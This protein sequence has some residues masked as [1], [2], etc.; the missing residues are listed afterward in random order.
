MNTIDKVD[1]ELLTVIYKDSRLSNKD[2]AESIGIAP[3]TSL[4]RVRR[5][6]NAGIIK[7]Y[8]ADVDYKALGIN[9]QVMAAIRLEKHSQEMVNNFRDSILNTREVI[10]V[11]HMG[12]ENDFIVHLA[13][14]DAE[15]LRDFVFEA[16]TSRPEVNHV[17]TAVIYEYRRSEILPYH[18]DRC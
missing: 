6:N 9:M 3:S 7:G 16:F 4:E 8:F 10:S 18:K 5:M 15:H 2:L 11:F 14:A 13:V 12:G 17:E 1:L